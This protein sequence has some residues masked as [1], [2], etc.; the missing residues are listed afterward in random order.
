MT[1]TYIRLGQQADADKLMQDFVDDDYTLRLVNA[2]FRLIA[3]RHGITAS[4]DFQ[5]SSIRIPTA[6]LSSTEDNDDYK[7]CLRRW[8]AEALRKGLQ[9]ELEA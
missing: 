7:Y 9:Q 5:T 1:Y 3:A 2:E 6:E 4:I 8:V